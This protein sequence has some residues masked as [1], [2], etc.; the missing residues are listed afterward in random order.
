MLVLQSS[1]QV[2]LAHK[3]FPVG[4]EQIVCGG[5]KEEACNNA[6]TDVALQKELN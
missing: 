6:S 4:I 5:W 3:N 1:S 2:C